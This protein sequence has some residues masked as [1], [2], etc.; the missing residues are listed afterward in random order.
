VLERSECL[1]LLAMGAGSGDTVG[2]VGFAID[3][4]PI[5][6]PVNY[7]MLDG[8]VVVRTG[9]GVKLL[10]ALQRAVVAFEVDVVDHAHMQAWSV[11]VR[12][13][14]TEVTDEPDLVRATAA[15]PSPLVAEPG[16]RYLRI[17]TGVL[18]GRRF[19]LHEGGEAPVAPSSSP[20]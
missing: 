3:G 15:T 4:V 20:A 14:C 5:I 11:L 17:R 8:D 19:P 13:L 12:G 18:T 1:R 9:E 7:G 6:L 16:D 10:S 2:R